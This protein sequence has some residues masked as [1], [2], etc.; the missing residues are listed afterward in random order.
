[1]PCFV[2]DTGYL[3]SPALLSYLSSSHSNFVAISE[4]TCMEC[5]KGDA[6]VNIE[7]SLRHV[8]KYPQQVIILN[9][10][11]T[12]I[13]E[14][15]LRRDFAREDLV[16]RAQ[17]DDF[18][19]FCQA[20]QKAASGD[21]A[22]ACQIR[23]HAKV[24]QQ[25]LLVMRDGAAK[26][27]QGIRAVAAGLQADRLKRIRNG[28]PLTGGD[29]QWF[30]TVV[31]VMAQSMFESRL[32]TGGWPA[33]PGVLRHAWLFRHALAGALL[34]RWWLQHGGID[35]IS[36]D[37][38]QNDVLDVSIATFGTYLDGVLTIDTKLKRIYDEARWVLDEGLRQ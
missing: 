15:G 5:Y 4:Y 9:S 21:N 37:K 27:V 10:V 20:V 16:C 8:M 14:Q 19:Q 29:I 7:R 18:S 2:V 3:R 1:M 23:E 34:M 25:Q 38:V 13:S 30:L 17:T 32:D 36:V 22:I 33:T 12:L 24:A 26:V 28:A 6:L 35:S 31:Q 11:T